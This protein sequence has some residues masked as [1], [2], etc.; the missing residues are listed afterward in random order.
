VV[1]IRTRAEFTTVLENY[2]RWRQQFLDDNG[3][4]LPRFQPAPMVASFMREQIPAVAQR[5]QIPVP[6]GPV[7]VW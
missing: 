1:Q 7:E 5:E 2:I 3:E 4:L 6:R